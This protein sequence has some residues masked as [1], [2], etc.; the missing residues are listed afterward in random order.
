MRNAPDS[1]PSAA[2][3]PASLSV[4]GQKRVTFRVALRP[5]RTLP[6]VTL[7]RDSP[8]S[9]PSSPGCCVQQPQGTAL[10]LEAPHR[11]RFRFHRQA[12][13]LAV[14]LV[15]P[16]ALLPPGAQP[17]GLAWILSLIPIRSSWLIVLKAERGARGPV[18]SC[19]YLPG[20]LARKGGGGREA[21]CRDT[22]K[23]VWCS[24]RLQADP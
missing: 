23:S 2:T 7:P 14:P 12:L 18:S 15:V 20:E 3:P 16:E 11:F 8:G 19:D 22:A 1:K 10:G 21:L 4:R 24:Q 9:P 17:P 6:W 13:F 5:G